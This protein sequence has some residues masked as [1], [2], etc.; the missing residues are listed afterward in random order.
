[1]RN[2]VIFHKALARFFD[3]DG[4][5][6]LGRHGEE[7]FSEKFV[8]TIMRS[9]IMV[10]LCAQRLLGDQS[11]GHCQLAT[12][13]WFST[14]LGIKEMSIPFATCFSWQEFR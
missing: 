9:R 2:F 5:E 8:R 13:D 14:S 6:R 10:E 3:P 1:M 4:P 7:I 11:G 12:F